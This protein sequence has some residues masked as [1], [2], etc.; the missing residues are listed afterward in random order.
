M[1]IRQLSIFVE[2][3]K[4]G[5]SEILTE[6]GDNDIDI[7]ALSLADTTDFGVLRLIVNQVEKAEQVL[8]AHG[9][10]VKV[11]RVLGLSIQDAPGKLAEALVVLNAAGIAIEYMY[12][13]LGRDEKKAMVVLRTDSDDEAQKI[14]SDAGFAVLEDTDIRQE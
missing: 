6:L 4:G 13:F 5:L 1:F 3:R 10:A 14:L 12:A 8:K 11:N 2:N 9:I 7:C